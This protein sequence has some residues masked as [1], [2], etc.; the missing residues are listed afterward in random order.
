MSTEVARNVLLW[1]T[2]LDYGILVVWFLF[3]VFAHDWMLGIHGR[4]FHLSRDQF[5]ALHY[6]G[7]SVFK[8]G[9]MLFNLVPFFALC[10]VG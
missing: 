3:F 9:I 7:M 6:A 5:D 1:A 10:I 8:I 4:W 2:V